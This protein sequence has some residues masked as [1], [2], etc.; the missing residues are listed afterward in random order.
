MARDREPLRIPQEWKNQ[1]RAFVIQ[2]ERIL[3][4]IFNRVDT[5]DEKIKKNAEAIE[6]L[7]S[8]KLD[9]T[10]VYNGLDKTASGFALDARQGKVLSDIGS[11]IQGALAII[12]NGDTHAAISSGEY[13]YVKNNTH[14]LADGLYQASANVAEN[15][16]ISNSNMT[17]V[18]KG[19]GSILNNINVTNVATSFADKSLTNNTSTTIGSFSLDKGQYIITITAN[20]VSNANGYRDLL[21]SDTDGGG[22]LNVGA[23]VITQ[24]V[25]GTTTRHQLTI[26][27]KATAQTTLYV[28]GRQTSGGAL[29]VST[30][31]SIARIQ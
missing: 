2:L 21:V 15:G 27:Y 13:V 22:Q 11:T 19:I 10:K 9:K 3:D 17:A 12:A 25:D 28:V 1:A 5:N 14:N 16:A 4:T 26:M 8:T 18:N 20:W 29:S 23:R 24:A 7:D 6:N 30:R 31:Y